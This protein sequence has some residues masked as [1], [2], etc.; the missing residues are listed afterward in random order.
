MQGAS[1]SQKRISEQS[2]CNHVMKILEWELDDQAHWKS[3]KFGCTKCDIVSDKPLYDIEKRFAQNAKVEEDH[4]NC[5]SVPC[6]A[7]KIQG[8][9]LNTGD[10]GRPIADKVWKS[11]LK[12]YSDA[13]RQGIQ[14]A[15]TNVHA[16]R[17]AVSASEK[18]GR[19]YNAETMVRADKVTKRMASTMNQLGE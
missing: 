13:R 8:L 14:P 1:V 15:N 18:L 17:A 3:S 11:R 9:Q 6:F 12:E 2:D 7:C 4:S 16:V 19:A 10:A 5:D